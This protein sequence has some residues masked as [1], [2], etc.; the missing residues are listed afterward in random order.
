M[1]SKEEKELLAG[2]VRQAVASALFED[3]DA[4]VDVGYYSDLAS[5]D[6]VAA[7]KQVALWLRKLPGKIWD[8]RL[9]KADG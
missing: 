5:I 4:A 7:R 3:W 2:A 9:G 8:T 1:L 6:P